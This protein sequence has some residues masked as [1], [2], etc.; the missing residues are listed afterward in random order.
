MSNN[1]PLSPQGN[2]LTN[3]SESIDQTDTNFQKKLTKVV[4]LRRWKKVKITLAKDWIDN[5]SVQ[6]SRGLQRFAVYLCNL[7][8]NIGNEQN[9][10]RP[11]III[12]RNSQN[13]TAGNVI[14][15]PLTKQLRCRKDQNGRV[16]RNKFGNP[17]PKYDYHYFLFKSKYTFLDYD[18]NVKAE[19]ITTVSKIRIGKHLGNI[20][21]PQDIRNIE[22][23]VK[24]I[25]ELR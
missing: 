16:I 11:V 25:L 8:E 4:A 17:I 22:K 5:E 15:I 9:E 6:K 20:T 21:D 14:V 7:G 3:P 19:D 23:R 24:A 1:S 13:A 10:E 12:S 18:S 2:I